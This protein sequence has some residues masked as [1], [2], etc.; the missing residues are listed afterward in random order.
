[1]N[2]LQMRRMLVSFILGIL[3]VLASF[4]VALA[5]SPVVVGPIHLEGT[6]LVTDC[7]TFQIND[8]YTQD[9]TR[10]YFYDDEGNLVK[11]IVDLQGT[12]TLVNSVKG[13]AYS[14]SYHNQLH[15]DPVLGIGAYNGIVFRLAIPGEGAV[16][17][18]VG[19]V[20]LEQGNI[21]FEAGPHQAF[22]GDFD[23]L[24]AALA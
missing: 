14:G 17:L 6:V 19:K 1:M 4:S 16:F 10:R 9:V 5:N 8:N 12:D 23:R 20:V 3:M 22:D 2:S 21:S 7:G 13:N 11:I 24:C 18:D 15:I